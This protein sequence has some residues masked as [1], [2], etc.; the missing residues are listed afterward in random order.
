MPM[1]RWPWSPPSCEVEEDWWKP[2]DLF[3][4]QYAV[5]DYTVAF[6]YEQPGKLADLVIRR[7]PSQCPA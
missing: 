7:S 4:G 1:K 2:A 5:F 3:R 6:R